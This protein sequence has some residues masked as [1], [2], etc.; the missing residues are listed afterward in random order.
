ML[1]LPRPWALV[2]FI[3]NSGPNPLPVFVHDRRL[4]ALALAMSWECAS[5]GVVVG[6]SELAV[7]LAGWQATDNNLYQI[8]QIVHYEGVIKLDLLPNAWIRIDFS[9]KIGP[10]TH[11]IVRFCKGFILV[12]GF[13]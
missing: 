5:Q 3:T 2:V 13:F 11:Q 6:R 1:G 8:M 9:M 4:L 12:F 7:C 10:T